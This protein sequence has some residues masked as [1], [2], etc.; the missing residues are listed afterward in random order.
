MRIKQDKFYSF[1]R[2]NGTTKYPEI[3]SDSWGEKTSYADGTLLWD[4][5]GNSG[6]FWLGSDIY[7]ELIDELNSSF[8]SG[9]T[10]SICESGENPHDK[11]NNIELKEEITL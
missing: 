10:I 6:D 11:P 1:C 4:Q 2:S 7:Q 5:D 9:Y 8:N 3:L